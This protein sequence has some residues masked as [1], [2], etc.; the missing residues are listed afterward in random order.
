MFV[1]EM[2]FDSILLLG[3]P[4]TLSTVISQLGMDHLTVLLHSQLIAEHVGT[5]NARDIG[6]FRTPLQF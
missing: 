6:R 5:K 4:G 1:L 2:I 3:A